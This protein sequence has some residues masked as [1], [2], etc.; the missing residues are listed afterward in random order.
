MIF[1][2][3]NLKFDFEFI[4]LI[5]HLFNLRTKH[6]ISIINNNYSL[7]IL[8]SPLPLHG[9]FLL[10]ILHPTSLSLFFFLRKAA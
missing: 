4:N 9:P 8:F 6:Q 3:I 5:T 7:V 10:Q 1:F 2:K